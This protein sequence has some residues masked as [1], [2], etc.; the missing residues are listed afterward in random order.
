MN[1][2]GGRAENDPPAAESADA[3]RQWLA[4]EGPGARRTAF[5]LRRGLARPRLWIAVCIA[6]LAVGAWLLLRSGGAPVD[7]HLAQD[8]GAGELARGH[9]PQFPAV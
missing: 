3:G 8:A 7:E 9:G 4:A 5:S 1:E 6:A 2:E